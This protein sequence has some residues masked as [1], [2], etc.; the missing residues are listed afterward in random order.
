M[1]V[2]PLL[3]LF[4]DGVT[5]FVDGVEIVSQVIPSMLGIIH[6]QVSRLVLLRSGNGQGRSLTLIFTPSAWLFTLPLTGNL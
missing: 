5:L 2:K 1:D 6:V 4:V 3:T